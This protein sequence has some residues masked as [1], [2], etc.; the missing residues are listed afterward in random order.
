M[1][2]W[3]LKHFKNINI[4]DVYGLADVFEN[5]RDVCYN[6][7]GLDASHYITAP[8]LAWDASLKMTGIELELLS[9]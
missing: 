7:Y 1:N 5:F 3:I 6:D 8:S 2:I 4:F 9:D